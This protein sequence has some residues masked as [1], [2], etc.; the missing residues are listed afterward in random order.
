MKK[1]VAVPYIIAIVLGIAVLALLGY[2]FYITSGSLTKEQCRTDYIG[3][4]T[5]WKNDG[6]TG[7]VPTLGTWAT[8]RTNCKQYTE[9]LGTD[10]DCKTRV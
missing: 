10:V 2:W 1:G 4:C 7:T 3:W 8:Y 6:W 5:H 9:F